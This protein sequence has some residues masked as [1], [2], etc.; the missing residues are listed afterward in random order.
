MKAAWYERFGPAREVLQ[1]GEMPRPE[2]EPGEVLVRVYAS[3][4]NPSDAKARMGGPGRSM[5]WPRVIPHQD[6]AGIIDSVGD[7]VDPVRIGERVW[8]YEAQLGRPSGT[9]AEYVAVPAHNTVPLPDIVSF[10]E[11]ACLG[12][13][14][15][16]AHNAVLADGPVA[17]QTILVTGG[18]GSVGFYAIQ[19]AK[20]G[21]AAVITSVS[22]QAQ[23]EVVDLAGADFIVNRKT[24]NV[25]ARIAEITRSDR[26]IDRIVEVAFGANLET[27]LKVLKPRGVI[28][29]YA[30]DE[31]HNPAI[32][33]WT[34]TRLHATVHFILV[35][36]MGKEAHDEAIAATSTALYG[37]SLEHHIGAR[38]SLDDIVAAHEAVESGITIGKVIVTIP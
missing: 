5:S 27:S 33:F 23:A 34:L 37:G 21:G 7:G 13:P 20:L 19:F 25:A 12:V 18:A 15:L 36:A 22:R 30:S 26:G 24:E 38:F 8:I 3:G 16:T 29:T 31:V 6:G 2:P 14:A 32:P 17:G 28:A 10:E 9:A 35:Y 1:V 4:V 11:G